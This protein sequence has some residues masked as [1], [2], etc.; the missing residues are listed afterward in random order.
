MSNKRFEALNEEKANK[1][2]LRGF[3]TMAFLGAIGIFIALV[4]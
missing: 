1:D 3:G 2:F 4:I